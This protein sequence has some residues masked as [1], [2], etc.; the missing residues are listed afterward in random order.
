MSSYW[1]VWDLIGQGAKKQALADRDDYDP[2]KAETERDGIERFFDDL[3]GRTEALQEEG[4]KQYVKNLRNSELGRKVLTNRENYD[5]NPYTTEQNLLTKIGQIK[6]RDPLITAINATGQNIGEGAIGIEAL[7]K[8]SAPELQG[9]LSTK[10][11]DAE[12]AAVRRAI[13][14][15]GCRK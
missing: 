3:T 2:S 5:I 15:R 10:T 12:K 4:R 7:Q 6:R 1:G 13:L 14:N 8:M 11:I 9:I